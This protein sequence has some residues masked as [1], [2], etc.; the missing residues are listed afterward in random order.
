MK[1]YILLSMLAACSGS[2]KSQT[3]HIGEFAKEI[4]EATPDGDT[5]KLSSLKGK[6]VLV[7]FWASWCGPCREYSPVLVKVYKKYKDK[8][9][10][11]YSVSLDRELR[12]WMRAIKSDKLS[13]IHVSD[14]KVWNSKAAAE[15]GVDAI[16]ASVL[17]DK[18]GRIVAINAERKE[19]E[20][21]LNELLK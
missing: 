4:A 12:K 2:L 9:F 8:G 3:V 21:K 17:L 15:Y 10:E 1:K 16:P 18:D 14:L 20:Q 11:I 19:L 13:W 6:V 7:D 5:I